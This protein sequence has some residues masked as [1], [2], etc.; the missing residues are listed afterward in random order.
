MPSPDCLLRKSAA[1]VFCFSQLF[2]AIA[3]EI[4]ELSLAKN[5]GQPQAGIGQLAISC[6]YRASQPMPCHAGT[7][8]AAD[9]DAP[10]GGRLQSWHSRHAPTPF[11]GNDSQTLFL[12]FLHT[13]PSRAIN[14]PRLG[15]VD[16][17]GRRAFAIK[18]NKKRFK[19]AHPSRKLA[20][21]G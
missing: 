14:D 11:F 16:R 4:R 7:W 8:N 21:P 6:K 13:G 10:P 1:A 9:L 12:P 18:K 20:M 5:V 17:L 15:L 19:T 3:L 2:S